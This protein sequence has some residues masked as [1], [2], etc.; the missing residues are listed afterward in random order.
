MEAAKAQR[1]FQLRAFITLA[2]LNL[3]DCG[4]KALIFNIRVEPHCRL[5][6]SKIKT[7][8]IPLIVWESVIATN[9]PRAV[10]PLLLYQL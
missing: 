2:A 10:F 4:Q 5:L 9:L 1:L 8:P 6:C 7:T 3:G